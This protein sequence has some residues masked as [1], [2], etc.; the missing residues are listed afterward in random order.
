MFTADPLL[1]ISYQICLDDTAGDYQYWTNDA[2]NS[3][4]VKPLFS[5]MNKQ[6]LKT[7]NSYNHKCGAYFLKFQRIEYIYISIM[8]NEIHFQ[9]MKYVLYIFDGLYKFGIYLSKKFSYCF[10]C[11][12]LIILIN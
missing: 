11:Y 2:F 12:T 1:K 4:H 3:I 10:L 9:L 8:F 7:V 5:L 6:G